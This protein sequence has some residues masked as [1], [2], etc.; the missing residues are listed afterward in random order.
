MSDNSEPYYS[1][2]DGKKKTPLAYKVGG[3]VA[4]ATI[5]TAIVLGSMA[6]AGV[7]GNS[8][9]NGTG[10]F[11]LTSFCMISATR[12]SWHQ[13]LLFFFNY[14]NVKTGKF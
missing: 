13:I 8:S 4:G 14:Y 2:N 1:S 10:L 9:K 12:F 7:F 6:A 11:V 3:A 5:L